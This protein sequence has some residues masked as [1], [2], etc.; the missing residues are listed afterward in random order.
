MNAEGIREIAKMQCSIDSY[1]YF[2]NNLCLKL[3]NPNKEIACVASGDDISEVIWQEVEK[4][5]NKVKDYERKA[6]TTD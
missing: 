1:S 2:L 4:L 6:S 3:I 5:Q